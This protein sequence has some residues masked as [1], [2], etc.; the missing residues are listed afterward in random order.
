MQSMC[1]Q[2][3]NVVI[4]SCSLPCP[5]FL[6]CQIHIQRLPGGVSK[7]LRFNMTYLGWRSDWHLFCPKLSSSL[8]KTATSFHLLSTEALVSHSFLFLTPLPIFSKHH[9]IFLQ[10]NIHSL[11]IPA[12]S[13]T[14][15]TLISHLV[16]AMASCL[17]S[18]SLSLFPTP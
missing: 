10:N 11:A 5:H 3:P 7:Y 9:L 18:L 12:T 6:E 2:L 15:T 4:S 16:F 14:T 17:F 13:T 8:V 1:C